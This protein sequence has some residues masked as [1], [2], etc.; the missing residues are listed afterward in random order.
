MQSYTVY[1]LQ[2]RKDGGYYIGQTENLGAR[3]KKHE[4]GQVRSTK[5]RR[6]FVLIQSE[7]YKTRGEAR[8][9]ENYLKSLKGGNEFKKIISNYSGIV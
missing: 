9:R 7:G 3:V 8:K 1:I 4:L 5:N 6:P 2:S